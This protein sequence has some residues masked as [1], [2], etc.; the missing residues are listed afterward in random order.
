MFR[1][2][3]RACQAMVSDITVRKLAEEETET[4]KHTRHVD[5]FYMIAAFLWKRWRSS[6]A[7]REFPISIVMADVDH[8]KE[9]N[10]QEGHAAGDA[11]SNAS[12]GC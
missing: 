10:D 9:T 8:L 11:C 6:N 4:P 3:V 12:P 1:V 7:R 2:E 5:R